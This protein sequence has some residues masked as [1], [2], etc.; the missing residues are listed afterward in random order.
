MHRSWIPVWGTCDRCCYH[1]ST[2]VAIAFPIGCFALQAS[3]SPNTTTG[4]VIGEA[5]NFL[6]P[7]T[8][9][10][11]SSHAAVAPPPRPRNPADNA[12]PGSVGSK[13][14]PSGQQSVPAGSAMH[15]RPRA[16]FGDRVK[17]SG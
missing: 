1:S 10:Q 9:L 16:E 12:V 15:T 11:L 17:Y 6:T 8:N 4:Y 7:L 14:L 3:V 2:I 13:L 5:A